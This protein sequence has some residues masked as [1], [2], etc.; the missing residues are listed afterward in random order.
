M[1]FP[2]A[3]RGLVQALR[4]LPEDRVHRGVVPMAQ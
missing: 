1:P 4:R 2:F 3:V